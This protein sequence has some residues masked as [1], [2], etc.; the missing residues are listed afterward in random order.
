MHKYIAITY[1]QVRVVNVKQHLFGGS[2]DINKFKKWT[3][4]IRQ[5]LHYLFFKNKLVNSILLSKWPILVTIAKV[6]I[7]ISSK[8]VWRHWPQVG[9]KE[10]RVPWFRPPIYSS[11]FR[12]STTSGCRQTR[13]LLWTSSAWSRSCRAFARRAERQKG[14]CT[15]RTCSPGSTE[16]NPSSSEAHRS[17]RSS[18]KWE[19]EERKGTLSNWSL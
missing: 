12:W 13:R 19:P 18:R 7:F 1:V 9:G 8:K 5:K 17:D 15:G 14:W 3:C 11:G 16:R 10:G 4:A 2:L 6:E